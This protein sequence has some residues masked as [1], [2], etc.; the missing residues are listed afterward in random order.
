LR[1]INFIVF[2]K[3]RKEIAAGRPNLTERYKCRENHYYSTSTLVLV[4]KVKAKTM[5]KQ[6]TLVCMKFEIV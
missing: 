4:T 6:T 1:K 2:L 3:K 5:N